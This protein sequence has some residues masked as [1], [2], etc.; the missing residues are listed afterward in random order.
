MLEGLPRAFNCPME[1]DRINSSLGGTR[2][3]Y[4]E[5]RGP[6]SWPRSSGGEMTKIFT[7]AVGVLAPGYLTLLSHSGS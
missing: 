6:L 3:L 7:P 1:N 2:K 4:W 5:I